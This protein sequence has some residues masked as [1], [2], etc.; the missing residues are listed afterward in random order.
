LQVSYELRNLAK[1]EGPDAEQFKD[2]AMSVESFA[3]HLIE[4][5]KSDE[6][7]RAIF[8]GEDFDRIADQ[9]VKY[10]QKKVCFPS[11]TAVYYIGQERNSIRTCMV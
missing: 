5:L 11:D 8:Q 6:I 4:P 10:E 1:T 3:I 7:K 2:L 9:A